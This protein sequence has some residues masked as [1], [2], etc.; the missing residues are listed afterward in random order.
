MFLGEFNGPVELD[1]SLVL[2][3]AFVAYQVNLD[4]L[5]SMLLDFLEPIN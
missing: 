5:S 3:V 1:L 4:V 2:E